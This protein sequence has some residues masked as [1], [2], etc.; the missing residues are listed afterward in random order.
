MNNH[1]LIN[2]LKLNPLF[3]HFSTEALNTLL[4]EC[5]Y[6][7]ADY[8]KNSVVHF[9]NEICTSLDIIIKGDI[10]IQKIDENGN[11]LTVTEFTLGDTMGENLL[12]ST[13]PYYPLSAITKSNCTLLHLSKDLIIK[14]CQFNT[15]FL[16]RFLECI[17]NKAVLLSSRLKS[18]TLKTIKESIIDY[19]N[20]EY[21][22]QK[23]TT[24]QLNLTKKALAE[25]MGIQRTSLSRELNKMQKDG[26]IE[27]DHH[28]ITVLDFGIIRK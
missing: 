5:Q 6:T 14:L 3:S 21:Y 28:S 4:Y 19:I 9:E 7:I 26:L 22:L 15:T 17:S 1:I 8:A 20:Y 10:I 12:F 27:Y 18:V 11:I 16:M 24:I 2:I 25:K 23:N 13:T